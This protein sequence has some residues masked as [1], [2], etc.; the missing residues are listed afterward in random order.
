MWIYVYKICKYMDN[1]FF[2]SMSPGQDRNNTCWNITGVSDTRGTSYIFTLWA[3]LTNTTYVV[4]SVK[5]IKLNIFKDI[6][7]LWKRDVWTPNIKNSVSRIS[8]LLKSV[9]HHSIKPNMLIFHM[10]TFG[11]E[12]VDLFICISFYCRSVDVSLYIKYI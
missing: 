8:K 4:V 7:L 11:A 5:Y 3:S 10:M 1:V 6:Y 9:W 2:I 12:H